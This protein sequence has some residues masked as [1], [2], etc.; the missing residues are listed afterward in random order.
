MQPEWIIEALGLRPISEREAATIATTPGD[1]PGTTWLT[2]RR[3]GEGGEVL[4]KQMLIDEKGQVREHRLYSGN[5]Q[6]LLA[7]AFIDEYRSVAVTP[8]PSAA[9]ESSETPAVTVFVPYR[10]RL[11]WLQ[12]KLA[13]DI[14]MD[15]MK[16]NTPFADSRREALFT[17]PTIPGTDRVNL[18][19]IAP[20]SGQAQARAN[21][22]DTDVPP[23]YQRRTTRPAPPSGSGGI[24]LQEPEPLGAEGAMRTPRE[25]VA[26]SAAISEN[27]PPAGRDRVVHPEIPRGTEP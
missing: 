7:R 27:T 21:D 5:K 26:L 23:A 24:Q 17:E 2:Q 25:P 13:L 16:V 11:E 3:K 15:G 10:F 8:A 14:T 18:A 6:T 20:K 9:G 12:E 1:R 19:K 4:T 22:R